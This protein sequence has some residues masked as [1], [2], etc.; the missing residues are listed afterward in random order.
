MIHNRYLQMSAASGRHRPLEVPQWNINMQLAAT[1]LGVSIAGLG[2]R[3]G[4]AL[5]YIERVRVCTR[6]TGCL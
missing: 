6:T 3:G 2:L 5:C 1:G 4:S